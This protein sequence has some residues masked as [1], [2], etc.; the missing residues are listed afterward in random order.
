V[1]AEAIDHVEIEILSDPEPKKPKKKMS[2]KK[3]LGIW[4]PILAFVT[5]LLVGLN[6]ALIE[7][8]TV[9]STQLG[10]GVFEVE[11]DPATDGWDT[12]YITSRF[13]DRE[14]VTAAGL[15]VIERIGEGGFILAQN[16]D[17]ALPLPG[18]SRVTLFGRGAADPILSGSGSGAVNV[19]G[20]VFPRQALENA[21][22]TINEAL[23]ETID[24]FRRDRENP[25]G[26][27]AMDNPERSTYY[28][29]ELPI[30]L[31]RQHQGT[32][33]TYNDAAIVFI[34]RTGGEGGDLQVSMANWDDNYFPG[35]HQLM[36]NHDEREMLALAQ[37]NFETVIVVLNVSTQMEIGDLMDD[38]NV[39][40][41]LIV[42]FPGATGFN[43]LPRVLTGQV[44]PSG[45]TV[46]TW[47]RDFTANPVWHNF[48]NF[49]YENLVL[50]FPV[51]L[52]EQFASGHLITPDAFFVNYAEGI[53][54]DYRW[55]TTAAE[56][57]FLDLDAAVVLPFG[58]GLSF[59]EF[60]W[61]VV[62]TRI[63]D[64]D[65][66]IEIDVRVTNT[67]DRAGRDVVQLYFSAPWTPGGIQKAAV[68][69][70]AFAKTGEIAPGDS[71]VVTLVMG[72]ED[73]ASYDFRDR[74]A[75]VLE[76]GDYVLTLRTDAHTLADGVAP[77]VHNI[78][79]DVVLNQR[80]HDFAEVTNLFDDVSA[81][82]SL[83][84]R[85]DRILELQREDI[86]GTFPHGPTPELFNAPDYI[87]WNGE[88]FAVAANFEN[89]DVQA[90]ADAFDGPMPA[91][92]V[93]NDIT[94]VELRGLSRDDPKWDDLLDSLSVQDMLDLLL[95]GAYQ[96][97]AIAAIAKPET[98]D[99]DG[100][101]G[102]SHFIDET[103]YGMALTSQALVAMTWDIDLAF[104]IGEILGNEAL[105]M[106]ISGWYAPGIN[107]HRSPF[108]GRNFEYYSADPL[109]SGRMAAATTQGLGEYGVYTMI[110]HFAFNDQERNR[111]TNGVATW[112]TE[113]AMREIYLRPFEIAIKD[114]TFRVPFIVDDQ[115]NHAEVRMGAMGV[116]SAYNRVG[117]VWTGGSYP[118]MT[119]VLR[120]E[121]GFEGFVISDFNLYPFMNADQSIWAGTDLTLSLDGKHFEDT[122]SAF[123][124]TNMRNA[125][126]NI[127]FGVTNSSA[128]NGIAP[129]AVIHYT[130]PM[131]VFMQIIGTAVVGLLV[132]GGVFMVTRRVVKNR[133]TGSVEPLAT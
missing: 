28:I 32:F 63:G 73:M 40:A 107:L 57:G 19:R 116:M 77:I 22:F 75:W 11:N 133:P 8:G 65:G 88:S 102:F 52:Q 29:G 100:P 127:L 43:A 114:V 38:P 132:A 94:L 23:F 113:Q 122:T 120:G 87:E 60:G 2:N 37:S 55:Y 12:Q 42:G 90:H 93:R 129:G 125:T 13:P 46:S 86:A 89:W 130:P 80:S 35:Q 50:D 27:I 64:I 74:R 5:V 48:G 101:A 15:A 71:D 36:L 67:G 123:A 3:Y 81:M 9:I 97:A 99:V 54:L 25:R 119:E 83:T 4:T 85:A 79:A 47:S 111:K 109:L 53:F 45:R 78:P 39:D 68:N 95:T 128:M 76:A 16:R 108:S 51:T 126:H 41:I 10:G 31:Y 7:F 96:T 1:N 49:R 124:R 33:A 69:L 30:S 72:V 106:G 62:D 14:A 61:E 115:G 24:E 121:W 82:F 44:N 26:R 17:D 98:L 105:H 117:S 104:E 70:G 59:T 103:V 110:K 21:G 58:H 34:S 66:D 6:W 131:G 112:L 92:N 56:M 20:A 118:L 91:V 18:P 84:P